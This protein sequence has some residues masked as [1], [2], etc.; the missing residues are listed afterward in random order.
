MKAPSP[1]SR[2]AVVLVRTS[3]PGNIGAAARAMKT[4]G[5]DDLVL[6]APRHF[7]HPDADALAAG[8]VDLLDRARV[9]PTLR[10]ALAARVL[11]VG[12]SARGRDLAHPAREW[13]ALAP[14]ALAATADGP[15]ALV[16]GN[17]TSGLSNDEILACQRH[18][19]IPANPEYPSLNLA[20]AVQVAGYELALA[21]AAFAVPERPR[22]A[23]A[24]GAD[25][26][27]L[28]ARLARMLVASGFLDPREPG[29]LDERMRRLAARLDLEAEEVA[30]LHGMLDSFARHERK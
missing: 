22:R 28:H 12:F 17:E 8:A 29:R 5:L 9:V 7:P 14:E 2:V 19:T 26:E 18:A 1:L 15:V 13:R 23:R 10:D 6:V 21:A 4:M 25:L 27:A 3:H 16:F 20:A 30:L 24:T 11:A